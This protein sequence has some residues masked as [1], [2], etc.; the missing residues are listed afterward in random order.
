MVIQACLLAC[1]CR[2]EFLHSPRYADAKSAVYTSYTYTYI[3]NLSMIE[4]SKK[5]RRER[6]R[7]LD[8]S[9]S[10]RTTWRGE[11]HDLAL[12]FASMQD[13]LRIHYSVMS[14]IRFT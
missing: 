4:S 6:E 11:L 9:K 10:V 2:A 8:N 14:N 5:K 7:A 1:E 12:G 13:I 3:D